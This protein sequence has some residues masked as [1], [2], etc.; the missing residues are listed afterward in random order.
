MVIMKPKW[1]L[2]LCLTIFT[3]LLLF[4]KGIIQMP[5][6]IVFA[7][8]VDSTNA[9]DKINGTSTAPSTNVHNNKV[10]SLLQPQ[11]VIS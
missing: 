6:F 9:G 10:P 1:S 7:Q 2:F 3:L 4:G 8:N 5:S 11:K